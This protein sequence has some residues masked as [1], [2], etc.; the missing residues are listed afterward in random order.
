MFNKN[1]YSDLDIYNGLIA[2]ADWAYK[3][4][5]KDHTKACIDFVLSNHGDLMDAREIEQRVLIILYENIK[6]GKYQYSPK[7]KISTYLF[8]IAQHQWL[9]E[10]KR[11]N[12]FLPPLGVDFVHFPEDEY[13]KIYLNEK[14]ERLIEYIHKLDPSCYKL[15]KYKYYDLLN[16][17]EISIKMG[18]ISI[19]NVRKRRYKCLQ[20]LK[21]KFKK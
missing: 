14:E 8:S 3:V 20:K 6:S 10:L 19:E 11:K 13:D 12:K 2:D 4:L 15:I 18:D 9:N 7:V 1:H 5:L 21:V 16:D 17:Q